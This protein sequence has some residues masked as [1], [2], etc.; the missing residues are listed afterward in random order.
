MEWLGY[1]FHGCG[2]LSPD[3]LLLDFHL[4]PSFGE[5]C[6]QADFESYSSRFISN[7]FEWLTYSPNQAIQLIIVN[8]VGK[9]VRLG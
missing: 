8:N 1:D 3:C 6:R 4:Y 5:W 9:V 7:F 2:S